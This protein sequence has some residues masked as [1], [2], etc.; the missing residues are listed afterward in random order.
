MRWTGGNKMNPQ[1]FTSGGKLRKSIVAPPGYKLGVV[2][3]SQIECRWEAELAGEEDLLDIFRTGA[4]PYATLASEIYNF[5]V[6]KADHPVERFM[7][8]TAR[9]GLGYGMGGPR[10]HNEIVTG[11]RGKAVPITLDF[12]YKVVN[13]YRK[14]HKKILALWDTLE[15][16]ME[17]M[18]THD[19]GTK[20]LCDGLL[21]FD[22]ETNKIIFPN[23]CYLRY[24]NL[25]VS[26]EGIT[27]S[28]YD[29]GRWKTKYLWGGT[30]TENV[31]QAISR[32]TLAEHILK[33]AKRY[34]IVMLTHDEIVF[35]I[36]DG[37]E[38]VAI[39]FAL[40]VLRT[41]PAWAPSGLPLD[42]EGGYDVCYSK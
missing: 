13:V 5:E 30:I 6:T 3:S 24:P 40:D 9:L 11:A 1:N 31:V 28:V 29:E 42:A 8:K 37:E 2:D 12:A 38:D 39:A 17:W 41:V 25:Q 7:G 23:G 35:L 20:V 32:H 19:E 36:P 27:Y 10:F 22:A 18:A 21:T 16:A 4:D 14:S 33:I 26:E 15:D 34:R